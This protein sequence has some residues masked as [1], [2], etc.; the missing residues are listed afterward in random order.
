M[1]AHVTIAGPGGTFGPAAPALAAETEGDGAAMALALFPESDMRH[2]FRGPALFAV[3]AITSLVVSGCGST[4]PR[5]SAT[6][7]PVTGTPVTGTP[8]TGTPATGTSAPGPAGSAGSAPA[9]T[10]APATPGTPARTTGLP[11]GYLPLYPFASLA[12]VRGWQASYQSGGHQPWHL[13]PDITATA[14]SAFLGYTGITQVAHR[15]VSGGEARVAVGIKLPNGTTSTAA[16]VHLLRFGSGQDAPWEVVGTNDTTFSLDR[17]AYGSTVSSPVTAG[18]TITGT[19]ENIRVTVHALPVQGPVGTYC[20]RAAGGTSSPWSASVTF[21]ATPGVVITI[22]AATGG[23]V[24][25]VERFAVTGA[26]A[27]Q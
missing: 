18:G 24:A 9:T 16:V 13:S 21:H 27:R 17:P 25:A 3:A 22:A 2:H 6:G 11:A 23:H 12:D 8:V 14:F 5:T 4:A 7:T 26:R 15:T 20:C 10:Q 19:D 1:N